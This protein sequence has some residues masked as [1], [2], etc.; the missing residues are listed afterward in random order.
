MNWFCWNRKTFFSCLLITTCFVA[1]LSPLYNKHVRK[2]YVDQIFD[3]R[4]KIGEGSFGLVYKAVSSE[5]RKYYALKFLKEHAGNRTTKVREIMNHMMFGQIENV[6]K[7]IRAWEEHGRYY[8]QMEY[9]VTSLAAYVMEFH[10]MPEGQLWDILADM[11]Q[12][13][14]VQ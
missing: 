5:D 10:F 14:N 8:I 3:Y 4:I 2:T 7:F 12:V 13:S 9:C 11:L 6:V 1:P